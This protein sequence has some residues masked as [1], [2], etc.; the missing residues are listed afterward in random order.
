MSSSI[1]CAPANLLI[2]DEENPTKKDYEYYVSHSHA[3]PANGTL[4][5][6]PTDQ[7]ARPSTLSRDMGTMGYAQRLQGYPSRGELLSQ[8]HLP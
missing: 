8:G 6:S 2:K 5:L 3:S 4:T 7:M 1:M